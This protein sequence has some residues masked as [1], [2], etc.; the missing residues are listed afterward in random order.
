VVSRKYLRRSSG[1]EQAVA[2]IKTVCVNS[3]FKDLITTVTIEACL[4]SLMLHLML[5]NSS[6]QMQYFDACLFIDVSSAAE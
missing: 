2:F 6:R 4:W 1:E 3:S 5:N